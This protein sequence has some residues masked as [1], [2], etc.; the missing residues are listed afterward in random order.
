MAPTPEA[1]LPSVVEATAKA[2]ASFEKIGY[3]NL[4]LQP[5]DPI[6]KLLGECMS[7]SDPHK[8]NLSVGA[9]RDEQ[10]RPWVLPVVQ[11]AKAVLLNDPTA[12]HEYFGLDGN[13]SFNEASARLILG[14]G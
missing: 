14:D 9:Y 6:F 4:T 13:K 2:T 5:E 8:I 3:T 11:K 7:D 10:G 12:N 1:L